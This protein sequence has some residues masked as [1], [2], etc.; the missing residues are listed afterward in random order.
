VPF[1]GDAVFEIGGA[2][3]LRSRD[4]VNAIADRLDRPQRRLTFPTPPLPAVPARL[5]SLLPDDALAPLHLLESL[6]HDSDV[7]DDGASRTF[8]VRPRGLA[9]ALDAVKT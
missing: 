4:L 8:D 6:R 1:D 3:R 7:G 2:D 9:A 5:A